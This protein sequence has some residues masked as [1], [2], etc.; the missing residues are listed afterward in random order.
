MSLLHQENPQ[1]I[2]DA[3]RGEEFTRGSG[4]V[5]WASIAATLLVIIFLYVYVRATQKPPV[6][7]GEIVQVWAHPNHVV[8]SGF[9]ANGGPMPRQSFDQVLVFA[10][11]KLINQ[12]KNPLVLQDVLAN[13]KQADGILSVSA[14]S[15]G[16]YDEVFLAYPELAALH[17]N[18]LS[19]HATIEPGQSVEGTAF[20]IFRMSRQEW[21]ARQD[22]TFTF[23]FQYQ[24]NLMLAP[25]TAVTEQ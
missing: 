13:L 4:H 15:T 5:V 11:V 2:D 16:Q 21:E 6:A 25:H 7:S 20:W 23:R 18:A 3:A 17:S 9:D 10:R 14:G 22:L 12:S 24:D 19:P 1:D 8:T